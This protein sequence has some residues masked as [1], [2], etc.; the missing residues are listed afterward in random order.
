MVCTADWRP[1]CGSNGVTYSNECSLK[2]AACL[3]IEDLTVTS[4]GDCLDENTMTTE[5]PLLPE[6]GLVEYDTGDECQ[7]NEYGCRNGSCISLENQCDGTIDCPDGDD[8]F[9][10]IDKRICQDGTRLD[11]EKVCNGYPDCS[12]GEDE[13]NCPITT[14]PGKYIMD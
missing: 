6:Y 11:E 4:S 10:C 3:G 13:Q 2:S 1:V 8:E 9:G 7:N 14:L 5:V 12:N